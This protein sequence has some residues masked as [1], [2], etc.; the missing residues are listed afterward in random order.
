MKKKGKENKNLNEIKSESR[1]EVG[2]GR[3]LNFR[4]FWMPL[5]QRI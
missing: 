4:V 5:S 2:N 3:K 1:V